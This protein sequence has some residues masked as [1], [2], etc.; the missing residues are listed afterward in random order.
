MVPAESDAWR[1]S[2]VRP[3]AYAVE[4]PFA[5]LADLVRGPAAGGAARRDGAL[6]RVVDAVAGLTGLDPAVMEAAS[7]VG[8]TSRQRLFRIEVP[9]AAPVVVTHPAIRPD[10]SQYPSGTNPATYSPIVSIRDALSAECAS[11]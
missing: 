6:G 1:E 9:L 8:M 11:S 5:E 10:A 3:I 7:A 2:I 4:P